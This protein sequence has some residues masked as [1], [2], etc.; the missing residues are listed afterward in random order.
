VNFKQHLFVIILLVTTS[1]FQTSPEEALK[2]KMIGHW[3]SLDRSPALDFIVTDTTFY[4]KDEPMYFYS[5]D[6]KVNAYDSVTFPILRDTLVVKI[7]FSDD[8]DTMKISGKD[9]LNLKML[10][11]E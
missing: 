2:K 1:C 4:V 11:L 6:Y 3:K 7:V 5:E 9:G 8:A 10:R